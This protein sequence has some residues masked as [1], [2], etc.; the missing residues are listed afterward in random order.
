MH[1]ACDAT[2]GI[3]WK[4]DI[5][6]LA[7]EGAFRIVLENFVGGLILRCTLALSAG[8]ILPV[9]VAPPAWA[10]DGR[11]AVCFIRDNR[12]SNLYFPD[13]VPVNA[14]GVG[15]VEAARALDDEIAAKLA[16]F[17]NA[18]YGLSLGTDG[19]VSCQVLDSMGTAQASIDAMVDVRP[20]GAKN[21]KTGWQAKTAALKA[22]VSPK[23]DSP[24]GYLTITDKKP[25][26]TARRAAETVTKSK[27][28][29]SSVGRGSNKSR[30]H[31]EGKRYVCPASKQ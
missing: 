9:L 14:P 17:V 12:N 16:S 15:D 5:N 13:A 30:C 22:K 21:V 2:T 25:A 20:N 3:G 4:A 23:K 11:G 18:K 26:P 19:T 1:S 28:P 29:P 24:G 31:L 6:G 7:A 8:L 10:Q 27:A